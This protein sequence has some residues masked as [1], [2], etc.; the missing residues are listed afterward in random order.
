MKLFHNSPLGRKLVFTMMLTSSASLLVA[1]LSFL[2]YDVLT[3]RRSVA[4]H[5]KILTDITGFNVAASLTYHDPKSANVV[6]Q[7]LHGEPHVVAARVYR[8]DGLPFASYLRDSSST[9]VQIPLRPPLTGT[10]SEPDRVTNSQPIVF[11]GELVGYLYLETDLRELQSRKRR[12]ALF[13]LILTAASSTSAFFVAQLLKRVICTPILDLVQTTK[14]VCKEKNFGIRSRKFAK[15]EFGLLADGFNEMLEEIERRDSELKSE[16]TFRTQAELTL[17]D[18]QA[19]LQLLLDSTAEAI[20]GIDRDGRCSFSNIACLRMLGYENSDDLLGKRMHE[21]VHHSR[22]DGSPYPMTECP[23]YLTM[24]SGHEIHT[25]REILWRADGTCFPVEAWSHPVWRDEKLVGGVVTFVDITERLHSQDALR[26][27]H[28]ESELFINSVPSILIGLNGQGCVIR[29]NSAAR[30]TFG[31]NESDVLGKPFATCGVR[32]SIHDMEQKILSLLMAEGHAKWD[33]VNFEKGEKRR[34]L[35]LTTT[36][37]T[38]SDTGDVMFLIVGADVTERRHAEE[39]LRSKTAFLEAQTN[40]T[41]DGILVV[42]EESNKLLQNRRF[43]E[44]FNVPQWICDQT[45]E[46]SLLEHILPNIRN[47]EE[48][49]TQV[50]YINSHKDE[51]IRDEIEFNNG[52]IFDRYS[53][54]VIGKDGTHYGRIWAFREITERKRNEDAVRQLSLAVE[55]SPV[56]VVITDLL[57][58]ITYVNQCFCASAGYEPEEVLGR[59]PRIFK[60]GHTSPDEYKEMWEAITR[61]SQWRGEFRNKKKNGEFYWESVVISPIKDNSGKPTHFI[62]FKEDVT[63]QRNLEGQLRQSQKLEA[64]GQLAAG[65]AH[66]INTPIQFIGDNTRFVKES[67]TSL[68]PALSLLRSMSPSSP[69]QAAVP[70]TLQQVLEI[71]ESVDS[72]YLRQEVPRALDQSLEGI[73]RVSKI[74]QA[75]KEFS[76]PGSDEKQLGDINKAI[77]TTLTVA[78]NEWKY[79]SEVET[80]LASDLELVPCHVGEFSQVILNLLINAAHAIGQVVGDA[81]GGKGK[82]TIRTKQDKDWANVSIQDTGA[83]IPEGIRSRIFEPFFTT[84]GVGKGTGQGL[85]LAHSTIVQKHSGRI[86]FES[87]VGKGTTFHIQLPMTKKAT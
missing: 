83:G 35:G 41:L 50:Q 69:P 71:L 75:M 40:A 60:S 52:R 22:A 48:Y 51:T 24:R 11:D 4:D 16:V 66:E 28:A 20:Y 31:L 25:D 79:V 23:S 21:L 8:S 36:K 78:R 43:A 85:A 3:F 19:Q 72:E 33:D 7:A 27:A 49:V 84:K 82:I 12:L 73:A 70:E 46:K 67:W 80:I 54:P 18:S 42:D 59:N 39:E 38:L 17:R 9:G 1:C 10:L 61:G 53:S 30:N 64:I 15:D 57:G 13:V 86:W 81:S 58:N 26:A 87:E 77:L 76:H 6:L 65:I 29:W 74:V 45:D 34:L 37:I 44:M 63:E 68:D 55:Q 2:S 56:S 62:A 32:W 47:P 14:Q 5:L